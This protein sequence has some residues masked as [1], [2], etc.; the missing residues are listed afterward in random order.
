MFSRHLPIENWNITEGGLN[1]N[2]EGARRPLDMLKPRFSSSLYSCVRRR[3]GRSSP[4]RATVA[5]CTVPALRIVWY[6]HTAIGSL[7]SPAKHTRSR[8]CST[9][10]TGRVSIQD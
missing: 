6:K 5:S 9:L 3:S 2:W 4:S 7:L 10:E 8:A 1:K